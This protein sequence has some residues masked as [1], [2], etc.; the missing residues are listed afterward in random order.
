MKPDVIITSRYPADLVQKIERHANAIQGDEQVRGMPREQ[1]LAKAANAVA[2][3]NNNELKINTEFLEHAPRLRIVANS[4][5]GFDNM[6]IAAMR[7][8][9]VYGTNCPQSYAADTA[10]HT[11][12]LLLAVTRRL[13]EADQYVRSGQWKRDGWMPGGRWDGISLGGKTL[14]IVGL[15]HIGQ[16]VAARAVTFGM[17]VRHHDPRWGREIAGWLSLEDLLA[18][19]DVISLHCPLIESTRHLIN[20]AAFE[21]MKQSAILLNVSRGPVV[22]IDDLLTALRGKRIFGA[23]LDVFEFEPD[24]PE[25]LFAMNNVVLSPHMGGCTVEARQ[26]AWRTCIENVVAVLA[27][28]P[29]RTPVF[30]L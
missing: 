1:V 13:I 9:G 14:G 11:I 28:Q 17:T 30:E 8:R 15:G 4:T 24:V 22:K 23:G 10:T 2:V 16:Q 5:A 6:D 26:D 20:A 25:E 18:T 12:A 21:R 29:P 27:G 19:S 3:I 7:Q